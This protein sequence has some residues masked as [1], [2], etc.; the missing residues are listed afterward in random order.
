MCRRHS[1]HVGSVPVARQRDALVMGY[2]GRLVLAVV[3]IAASFFSPVAATSWFQVGPAMNG[4]QA[5]AAFGRTVSFSTDGNRVAVGSPTDGSDLRGSFSVFQRDES[6]S[7]WSQMGTP[8]LGDPSEGTYLGQ[9]LSLS[10]DGTIIAVASDRSVRV[11][12][13][14]GDTSTWTRMS[15]SQISGWS[16]IAISLSRDGTRL[17]CSGYWSPQNWLRLYQYVSGQWVSSET[18]GGSGH[19]LNVLDSNAPH[20]GY[21]YPQSVAISADGK[22]V[23][24]GLGPDYRRGKTV[25]YRENEDGSWSQLGFLGSAANYEFNAGAAVALSA[26]GNRLI[27]AHP[28]W[29]D[30]E[31]YASTG[32]GPPYGLPFINV[33]EWCPGCGCKC[34]GCQ[35]WNRHGYGQA[36]F[37]SMGNYEPGGSPY[38]FSFGHSVSISDDGSIIAVGAPGMSTANTDNMESGRAYVYKYDSATLD[39][40]GR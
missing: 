1:I 6:S 22:T 11:Y 7:S 40:A 14:V 19:G 2:P 29:T 25:V 3:L 27:E 10:G 31:G 15:D 12:Q 36:A 38:I 32:M 23:A 18:L 39:T 35:C 30:G 9:S 17:V 20:N 16:Q 13:W 37:I 28:G 24:R 26:D 5:G 34:G 33:H 21:D 8:I 4:T